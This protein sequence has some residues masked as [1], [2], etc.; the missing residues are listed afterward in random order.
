MLI[1]FD[2]MTVDMLSN[3][4]LNPIITELFIRGRKGRKINASL[5][6]ITQTYFA[7]PENIKLNSKHFFVMKSPNRT[8]R[9]LQQIAFNCSSDIDF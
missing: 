1:F 4:Y 5:A 7:V 6:S 8:S 9:E 3:K 2:D